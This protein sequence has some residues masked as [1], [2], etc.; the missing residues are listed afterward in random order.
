VLCRKAY[1]IRCNIE[2]LIKEDNYSIEDNSSLLANK[3]VLAEIKNSRFEQIQ[4]IV[5]KANVLFYRYHSLNKRVVFVFLQ[6]KIHQLNARISRY[7]GWQGKISKTQHNLTKLLSNTYA[8]T[9][10]L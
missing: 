6:F 7:A 3:E 5:E 4:E 2:D 10:K 1:T 9:I 8:E